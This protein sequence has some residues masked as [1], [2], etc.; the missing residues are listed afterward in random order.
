M[1]LHILQWNCR[2]IY[3]KLPEFKHY[4]S[5][6]PIVLDILCLQETH[7]TSR[8]Y[9]NIPNYVMIRKDRP[10]PLEKGGGICICV[11][12][13]LSFSEICIPVINSCL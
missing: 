4:L 9:L 6:L 7:L 11:K 3:K 10:L 13:T 5:H 2:S 1:A 12:N 8:Y